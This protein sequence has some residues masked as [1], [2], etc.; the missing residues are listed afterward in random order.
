MQSSNKLR[1][2]DPASEQRWLQVE[3]HARQKNS[4]AD[5]QHELRPP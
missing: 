5:G 1:D 2:R 3:K 4:T